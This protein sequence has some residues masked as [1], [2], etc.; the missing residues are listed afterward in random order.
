MVKMIN[1]GDA[2]SLSSVRFVSFYKCLCL[3]YVWCC[4]S[5]QRSVLL[6]WIL[7]MYVHA[8]ALFFIA[9]ALSIVKVYLRG[10]RQFCD[11][12]FGNG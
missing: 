4:S 9:I 2:S 12:N 10:L 6:C 8:I 5:L 11:S 3:S 1:S 7:S